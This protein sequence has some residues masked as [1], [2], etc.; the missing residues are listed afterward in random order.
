VL[1]LPLVGVMIPLFKGVP[2]LYRWQIRRR[3]I[4]WYGRLKALEAVIGEKESAQDL[5]LHRA[6]LDVID[7]AVRNIPLPIWFAD[8]YYILRSAIDLV[9]Q[10]L[11]GVGRGRRM[12]AE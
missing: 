9:R 12:A 3:L 11:D 7:E 4:Y 6:E 10:R 8:Q 2:A 5:Q 1:V